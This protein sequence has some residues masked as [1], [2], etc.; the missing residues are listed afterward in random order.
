M[1]QYYKWDGT[2]GT[3]PCNYNIMKL[4]NKSTSFLEPIF[5]PP[6][7]CDWTTVNTTTN[8][9]LSYT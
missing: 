6:S 8:I 7:N 5:N 9:K 1:S 2:F 3:N 4:K